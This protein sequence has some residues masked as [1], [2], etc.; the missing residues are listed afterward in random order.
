M[1]LDSI[2]F[3]R[4]KILAYISLPFILVGFIGSIIYGHNWWTKAKPWLKYG[5]STCAFHYYFPNIIWIVSIIGIIILAIIIAFIF[6]KPISENQCLS[7]FLLVLLFLASI[8]N[9]VFGVVVGSMGFSYDYY[10]DMYKDNHS[11]KC[12]YDVMPSLFLNILDKANELNKTD[13]YYNWTGD[14]LDKIINNTGRSFLSTSFYFQFNIL[15]GGNK[16]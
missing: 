4:R 13:E 16:V 8:F 1:S 2:F 15:S 5:E 6:I 11:Y 10:D 9:W 7:V 12:Y 3:G 14:F